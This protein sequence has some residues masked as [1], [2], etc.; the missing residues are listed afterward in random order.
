MKL[1]REV[2]PLAREEV[3]IASDVDR[4]VAQGS[5]AQRLGGWNSAHVTSSGAME[6]QPMFDH[7][8]T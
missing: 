5:L 2:I 8:C 4:E 6:A 3:C 7:P 1:S